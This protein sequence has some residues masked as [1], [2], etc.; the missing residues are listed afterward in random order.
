M[1]RFQELRVFIA[2]AETGGFAKAAGALHSSP[3]AVT[4]AVAALEDRLGVLLFNRT[5][6]RVHLTETGVRFLED[7]KRVLSD[8]NAAEQDVKGEATVPTGE[9]AIT[10]P[11]AF[12]RAVLQPIV[13]DFVDANPLVSVSMLLLDRVVDLVEE[14][15]DLAVRI[16]DMPSSS[17][18]SSNIGEVRRVLVASPAYLAKRGTPR[19]PQELEAHAVIAHTTLM[20]DREWRHVD[21]G[22]S[23]RLKLTP[24]IV[25]NDVLLAIA[26]AEQDRGVTVA[27]S[28]M[29]I[30]AIRSGRLVP[31]LQHC[32]PPAVPVQMVYAQRRMVPPKIRS[33]VDFATPRLRSALA[34]LGQRRRARV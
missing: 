21:A 26:L 5:T 2:V 33:F 16:A 14:G 10:A 28:Y 8:L 7:A 29:V 11:V 32:S 20:S 17:L 34:N 25:T 13:A 15:F 31:L 23:A 1:D 18:V 4:R 19:R 22:K 30:D 12:G 27:L 3:P 9:V 6:R 24:R